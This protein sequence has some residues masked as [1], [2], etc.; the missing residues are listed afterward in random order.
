M[1]AEFFGPDVETPGFLP[2]GTPA[3]KDPEAAN[4]QHLEVQMIRRSLS[5]SRQ[6]YPGDIDIPADR[7]LLLVKTDMPASCNFVVSPEMQQTGQILY[8]K[9]VP[10]TEGQ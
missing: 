9:E 10:L 2:V 6:F 7:I 8:L 3:L 5:N 4:L 1:I